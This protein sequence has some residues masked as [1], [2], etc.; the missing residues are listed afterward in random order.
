MQYNAKL[1]YLDDQIERLLKTIAHFDWY[2]NS[3]I[4]ITAD[5]GESLGEWGKYG[6]GI[7]LKNQ[8][9]SIPMFVKYPR[10]REAAE[11]SYPVQGLD[12]F[13]T[14]L[15][16]AGI[17]IEQH[18]ESVNLTTQDGR[19]I[20]SELEPSLLVIEE[21]GRPFARPVKSVVIG[22]KIIYLRDRSA[23]QIFDM[24][25]DSK[26]RR[27]ILKQSPDIAREAEKKLRAVLSN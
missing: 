16:T 20:L 2:D 26:E 24:A 11:I 13:S 22:T 12:I 27:S 18:T 6:S 10:Q 1:R 15:E 7:T 14:A 21:Y 23:F 5:H 3:L 9:I 8:E 19:F 17:Q 4:I 25:S